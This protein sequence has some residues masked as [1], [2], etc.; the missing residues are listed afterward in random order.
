MIGRQYSERHRYPTISGADDIG[1]VNYK[2]LEV[3]FDA[4]DNN[5]NY[6]GSMSPCSVRAIWK[7]RQQR[8]P[9]ELLHEPR[10][11]SAPSTTKR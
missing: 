9:R 2:G 10:A 8:L 1:D 7:R 3:L 6:G 4:G 11:T 5:I